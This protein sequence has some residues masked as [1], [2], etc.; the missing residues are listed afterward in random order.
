MQKK[1]KEWYTKGGFESVIFVPA[2]PNS[3]LKKSCEAVIKRTNFKVKVVEK[4]GTQLKRILQTSNPFR[5]DQCEDAENCF[6]CKS[7]EKKNCRKNEIKY[8]ITCE[9]EACKEDIYH[10]ESS[11]N[12]YTRGGE[13]FA[14]FKK[15]VEGNP[16]WKHCVQKHGGEERSFKM[17]IDRTFRKDPMLRQI[18]EAIEINDTPEENRM[19]SKAEWH[20]PK[21]P[22]VQIGTD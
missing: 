11:R 18:T 13:Q 1:K 2:T 20:L 12:G 10:G 15:H 21:V 8:H 9:D 6:I 14:G 7:G 5:K 16:M 3:T 19:N 17:K 22:R 4:S